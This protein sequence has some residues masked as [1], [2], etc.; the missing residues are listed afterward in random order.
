MTPGSSAA[1]V[2]QGGFDQ[3]ANRP[4]PHFACGGL[5][6]L[7]HVFE[8]HHGFD[9]DD[10]SECTCQYVQFGRCSALAGRAVTQSRST[11]CDGFAAR[12]H[13]HL[14]RR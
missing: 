6:Q 5:I 12:E 3:S 4:L 11:R 1:L 7:Q 14:L 9:A 10:Q 13:P 2:L 8:D